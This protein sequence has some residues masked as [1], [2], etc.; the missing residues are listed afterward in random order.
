MPR[1]PSIAFL[2][3][4]PRA[5]PRLSHARA[6]RIPAWLSSGPF[7]GGVTTKISALHNQDYVM[8]TPAS[9]CNLPCFL[10]LVFVPKCSAVHAILRTQI[11]TGYLSVPA[12][13]IAQYFSTGEMQKCNSISLPPSNTA[14]LLPAISVASKEVQ[15]YVSLSQ[16]KFTSQS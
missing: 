5:R 4:G 14:L 12:T 1:R 7:S 3:P 13:E 2:D 15:P 6:A 10:I 9:F 11:F 8:R 16:L